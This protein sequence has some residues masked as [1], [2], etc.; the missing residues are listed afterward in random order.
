[1]EQ[2]IAIQIQKLKFAKTDMLPRSPS[3]LVRCGNDAAVREILG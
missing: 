3:L 1:M 2:V